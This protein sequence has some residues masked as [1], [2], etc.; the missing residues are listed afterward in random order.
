LSSDFWEKKKNNKGKKQGETKAE[1]VKN[2][3]VVRGI[4][5]R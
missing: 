3:Q 4:I 1:F 2:I 5:G